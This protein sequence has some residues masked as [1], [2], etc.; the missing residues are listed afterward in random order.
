MNIDAERPDR[1]TPGTLEPVAP[2]LVVKIV[3]R[4]MTKV[5]NPLVRKLAGRP[6]F[7]MAAQ[8]WHVGRRS[9]RSYMTPVI[10]PAGS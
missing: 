1:D 9:A 3:M 5:L 8:V 6:H 2:S 4:P 7:R 10:V